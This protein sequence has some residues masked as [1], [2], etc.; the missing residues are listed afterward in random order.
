MISF[1]SIKSLLL[2]DNISSQSNTTISISFRKV[3]RLEEDDIFVINL[4]LK[5]TSTTRFI[6]SS[7]RKDLIHILLEKI[8]IEDRKRIFFVI[9]GKDYCL[10]CYDED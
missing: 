10:E 9:N 3:V 7:I 8:N 1:F 4:M 2:E 6:F 5:R